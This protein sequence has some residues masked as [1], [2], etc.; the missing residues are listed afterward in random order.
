[1]EAGPQEPTEPTESERFLDLIGRG[2]YKDV[3]VSKKDGGLLRGGD[4]LDHP[5]CGPHAKAAILAFQAMRPDDPERKTVLE[6][7]QTLTDSMLSSN[8]EA[9]G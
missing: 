3:M 7:L 1:M 6:D 4:F 5:G 8:P 9:T 2:R